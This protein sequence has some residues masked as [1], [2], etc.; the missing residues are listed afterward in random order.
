MLMTLH[1]GTQQA[2]ALHIKTTDGALCL[3]YLLELHLPVRLELMVVL[4][5]HLLLHPLDGKQFLPQLQTYRQ[6]QGTVKLR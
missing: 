2:H 4:C 3:Q 6:Q 5:G 1:F